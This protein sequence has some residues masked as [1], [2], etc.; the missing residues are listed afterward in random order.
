MLLLGADPL[1]RFLNRAAEE[2][3]V[4]GR[5]DCLLW[6]AD[7][8]AWQRNVDVAADLRGS[9]STMLGAAKIVR[10]ANGMVNLVSRRIAPLKL[11]RTDAPQRGDIA[12]V[13]VA[14]DGGEHFGDEAG[15]ILLDG[16]VALICQAGIIF[17][18]IRAVPIR[19]A[20]RL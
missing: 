7:L 13:K 8:I 14:G 17:P 11:K 10:Q 19:A 15:A 4:W 18:S 16:T 12:V 9:Y 20:W 6:L 3:F 1:T 5:F 2:P